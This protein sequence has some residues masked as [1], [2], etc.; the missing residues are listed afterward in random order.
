M[1]R[2][3][4]IA[5]VGLLLAASPAPALTKA[6]VKRVLKREIDSAGPSSGLY[7]EDLADGSRF[8]ARRPD[9]LRIPASV[10]KLW[11]TTATQATFGDEGTLITSALAE[12][13]VSLDGTLDGNL[14]L[15]G[16]G[17]PSLTTADIKDLAD[18]LVALGVARTAMGIPLFAIGLGLTY[19]LVRGPERGRVQE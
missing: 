11:T 17:D 10:E 1:R 2:A 18:A 14:Y 15:R 16:G 3:L 9:T 4:W 13:R 19:L 7:V 12:R 6:Q 5:V 8:F